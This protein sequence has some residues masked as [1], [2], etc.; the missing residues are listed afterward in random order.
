MSQ[1]LR[2]MKPNPGRWLNYELKIKLKLF[3][4]HYGTPYNRRSLLPL[5]QTEQSFN[6][7]P[8]ILKLW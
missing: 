1:I 7:L 2:K 3:D 6:Y 5:D 4:T 8:T